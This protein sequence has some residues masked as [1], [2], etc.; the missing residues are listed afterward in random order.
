MTCA[1][2]KRGEPPAAGT[3]REERLLGRLP[4]V[5]GAAGLSPQELH[6]LLPACC[7]LLTTHYLL[8]A[9]CYLLLTTYYLT[10]QELDAD[11]LDSIR[12]RSIC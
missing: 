12:R 4:T 11:A 6:L 9:T 10:S 5:A 7:S 1:L 3:R 8:L 2:V